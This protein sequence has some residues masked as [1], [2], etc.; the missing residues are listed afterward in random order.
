MR[1]Q[2]A[3]SNGPDS[4]PNVGARILTI[5]GHR[6]LLDQDLAELY[7]V[8]T[9]RLNEAVKRN[10]QR[11]PEDFM[12]RLS[13]EEWASLISQIAISKPS[14]RGG[15]RIRTSNKVEQ[16]SGRG[17]AGALHVLRDS[18]CDEPEVVR[19]DRPGDDQN[20]GV[21]QPLREEFLRQEDE[22]VPVAG[23]QDSSLGGRE[24]QLLPVGESLPSRLVHGG[25]VHAH[26]PENDGDFRADVLIEANLHRGDR[27]AKGSLSRTVPSSAPFASMSSSISLG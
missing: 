7:G 20:P 26:G 6:V 4:T 12:F 16:V 18:L 10:I 19:G 23:H 14:A 9:Y 5:R 17:I 24:L 11:F 13:P 2:S 21:G 15:R 27:R 25:R 22:V 8:P 3:I 1:S